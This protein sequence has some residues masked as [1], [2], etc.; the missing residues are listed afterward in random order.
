MGD[1]KAIEADRLKKAIKAAYL[2]CI[3]EGQSE[4]D[5]IADIH[6]QCIKIPYTQPAYNQMRVDMT[7]SSAQGGLKPS[8]PKC[9]IG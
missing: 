8:P 1:K 7:I 2:I 4:E 3:K 5:W 9:P 6:K